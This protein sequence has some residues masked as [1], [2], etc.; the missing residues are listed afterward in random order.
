MSEK[1]QK[2]LE[3]LII[4]ACGDPEHQMIFRT[5][6]GDDDVYVSIYQVKKIN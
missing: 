2:E 1:K 3:E 5:I 6:N 4:C